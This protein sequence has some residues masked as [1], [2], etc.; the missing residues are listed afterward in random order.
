M[1]VSQS[2]I[3]EQFQKRQFETNEDSRYLVA[4]LEPGGFG[5]MVAR[6]KIAYQLG[7]AFNRTVLFRN[8]GSLYDECYEP[9]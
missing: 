2:T 7:Q 8:A 4:D 3:E 9:T 6:R 1:P 5:A